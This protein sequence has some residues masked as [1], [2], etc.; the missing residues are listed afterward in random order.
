MC[1]FLDLADGV[2]AQHDLSIVMRATIF[3]VTPLVATLKFARFVAMLTMPMLI[4]HVFG[5]VPLLLLLLM[6]S[7][8]F[9]HSGCHDLRGRCVDDWLRLRDF[10][11]C[12]FLCWSFLLMH[13]MQGVDNVVLVCLRRC[14]CRCCRCRYGCHI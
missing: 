2:L 6:T 5:P 8:N 13:K 12:F 9:V 7:P 4:C 14:R 11:L 1:C 10:F 3:F